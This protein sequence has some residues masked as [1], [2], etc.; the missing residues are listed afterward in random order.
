MEVNLGQPDPDP[1]ALQRSRRLSSFI[2]SEI[3]KAGGAIGFDRYM[4]LALY[5]PTLGYYTGSSPVFGPGG[6]FITAPESGELFARCLARQ[7]I[8]ILEEIGGSIVEYGGGSGRLA[9]SLLRILEQQDALPASY[10]IVEPSPR[11][12]CRQEAL[13]RDQVPACFERVRWSE[14]HAPSEIDGIVIANEV[15]DA[16]P[17]KRFI[18]VDGFL[19][20]LGVGLNAHGFCWTVLDPAALEVTGIE[21][22]RD[23]KVL[24]PDD[25]ISEFNPALEAWFADLSSVLRRA[26]VILIDYGYPRHEYFHPS[27]SRGTLKCH[28]QHRVHDD[29][30]LYPGE[31]D[32]TAAVDFTLVA[33]LA[34]DAGLRMAGFTTQT[35]FLLACGVDQ[36]VEANGE[37]DAASQFKLTQE[38]KRLLLPSAMGQTCKA[39]ALTADYSENLIGFAADE[40]HRLSGFAES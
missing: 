35:R 29:P 37:R 32:I 1:D 19:R 18:V 5:E 25:F 15:L 9:C 33:E 24:L 30:F 22:R 10:V 40:R 26:V 13:I 36:F 38:A 16:M 34:V 14:K 20:E 21:R 2:R 39:M 27:R 17:V 12:R 11:M 8:Q 4:Y 31:Q 28:F 6:D 3:Q 7:C 23:G